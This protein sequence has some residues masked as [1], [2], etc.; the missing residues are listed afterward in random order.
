MNTL[1]RYRFHWLD[2]TTNEGEG[3]TPAE[4]LTLLGFGGGAVR[5]LDYYETLWEQRFD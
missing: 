5:A 3:H 1:K 4:A 2:G